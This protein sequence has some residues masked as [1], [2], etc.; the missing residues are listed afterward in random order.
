M[1]ANT[2][3]NGQVQSAK[4]IPTETVEVEVSYTA[5]HELAKAANFDG[6]TESEVIEALLT[7]Y[8]DSLTRSGI[9]DG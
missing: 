5:Y 9:L 7:E 2:R 3:G 4:Q 8:A 1:S 6:S